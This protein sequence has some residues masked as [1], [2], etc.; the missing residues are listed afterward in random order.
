[1]TT[2]VGIVVA[3]IWAGI[4]AARRKSFNEV[5]ARFAYVLF[6]WCL[7]MAALKALA[8]FGIIAVGS[9]LLALLL[10]PLAAVIAGGTAA[11]WVFVVIAASSVYQILGAYFMFSAFPRPPE[12]ERNGTRL[13]VGSVF[14]VVGTLLFVL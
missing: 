6:V 12:T 7:G 10:S 2:V 3:G 5:C 8:W 11:T 13:A 1:M 4:L 9:G 14:F